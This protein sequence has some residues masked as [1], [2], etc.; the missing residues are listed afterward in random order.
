[1]HAMQHDPPTGSGVQQMRRQLRRT[2]EHKPAVADEIYARKRSGVGDVGVRVHVVTQD[3]VL[4][5]GH[6]VARVNLADQVL[7]H[8]AGATSRAL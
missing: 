3:P 6:L 7:G 2:V 4:G 8:A 5:V 1:M